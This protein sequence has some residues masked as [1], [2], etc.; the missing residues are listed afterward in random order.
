MATTLAAPAALL[1]ISKPAPL[2]H[3]TLQPSWVLAYSS[4][5]HLQLPVQRR[6]GGPRRLQT[7]TTSRSRWRQLCGA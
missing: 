6:R 5:P 7:W 3:T 1:H 4:A 2:H